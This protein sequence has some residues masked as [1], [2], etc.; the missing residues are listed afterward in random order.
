[1]PSNVLFAT[2]SVPDLICLAMST[3]GIRSVHRAT[4]ASYVFFCPSFIGHFLRLLRYRQPIH[5]L[6]RTA[7]SNSVL[8]LQLGKTAPEN[9]SRSVPLM[10]FRRDGWSIVNYN[11]GFSQ[12][13][14]K[15]R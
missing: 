6:G 15:T 5:E 1:M 4:I 9:L 7:R 2:R 12:N 3:G 14:G 11:S 13:R 8:L 10:E